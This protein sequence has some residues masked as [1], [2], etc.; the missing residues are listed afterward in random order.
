ML[1]TDP[2]FALEPDVPRNVRPAR[3]PF[4]RPLSGLREGFPPCAK[5]ADF[6]FGDLPPRCAP[7]RPTPE[8]YRCLFN[9]RHLVAAEAWMDGD[10]RHQLN[11][12]DPARNGEVL[13]S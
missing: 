13:A 4:F 10:W 2:V 8:V 7:R 9:R 6:S 11:A 12:T 1:M 5:G 3:W